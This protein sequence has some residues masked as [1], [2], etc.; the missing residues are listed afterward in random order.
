MKKLFFFKS[1][2]LACLLACG[3]TS[4]AQD[5]YELVTDASTLAAGDQVIIVAAGSDFALSTTQNKNNRGQ[6]EVTKVDNTIQPGA[7]VQILTLATGKVDG[8]FAFYTGA[9]YLYAASSSNNHLKTEETLS[10]NSSFMIEI[11]S[12]GT[13]TM[14]AQGTY[15]RNLLQYNKSSKLFSCYSNAQQAVQLYKKV[16]AAVDPSQPDLKVSPAEIDFGTIIKG[17]TFTTSQEITV[18]ATNLTEVLAEF[19]EIDVTAFTLTGAE[20]LYAGTS[21]TLTVACVAT[22]PGS[23]TATVQ[24]VG[25][26]FTKEV[27]LKAQILDVEHAGTQEDPFTVADVI[28]LNNTLSGEYWVEGVI[29]GYAVYDT[30]A[31]VDG[32]SALV[33]N[34]NIVL[35]ATIDDI[36]EKIDETKHVAVQ[37][38]SGDIRTALNVEDHPHYIGKPVKVKGTLA[39]YYGTAGVKEISA[40]EEILVPAVQVVLDQTT[41]SVDKGATIT[42]TATVTPVY[43]TDVLTWESSNPAIASVIDGVVEGLAKGD[44]VI[45]AKAGEQVETCA[46]TVTVNPVLNVDEIPI[47]FGAIKEGGAFESKSLAVEGVN[48]TEVPTATITVGDES[49]EVFGTLEEGGGTLTISCI[50][51]AVGEYTGELTVSAD[52]IDKVIALAAV[53]KAPTGT[54]EKFTDTNLGAGEY[55]FVGV[56]N[57]DNT[58]NAM[59]TT[60]ASNRL[61]NGTVTIAE[62]KIVNPDESVVWTVAFVDGYYTIYNKAVN[63]YAAATGA[64]N[65][66]QIMDEAT[67]TKAQWTA[68]QEGALWDFVNVGNSANNVNA[69]LRNNGTYGFACYAAG[70]GNAI[71]LFKK[72]VT[73]GTGTAL[74]NAEAEK[75]EAIK[76]IENGQLII[77]R[78]GVRY[79][80]LGNVIK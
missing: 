70:T 73:P 29:L 46:V 28:K 47:D 61:A 72:P 74:E 19:Q 76:V 69:N 5:T 15:T 34:S 53:I 31:I 27:T 44:V 68:T 77:I 39:S 10:D 33:G 49:F 1:C 12:D 51:T 23:Y 37:L 35:G 50:A 52:G 38:P 17:Q 42:L 6:A 75:V 36:A 11:A 63:G 16:E 55:I 40:Y 79:N 4:F 18:I 3:L 65:N 43:T 66:A 30:K 54:F 24:V 41:A 57:E 9:G 64:K 71:T 78:D 45:T 13:A 60:V 2:L 25:G 67:D 58:A 56:I 32:S 8:T 59:S 62:D 48:L 26:D 80:V 7:D 21:N 20:E 22:E 14:K